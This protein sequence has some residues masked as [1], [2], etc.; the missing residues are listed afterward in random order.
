MDVLLRGTV[1][2]GYSFKKT[3]TWQLTASTAASTA[4]LANTLAWGRADAL[5]SA[6]SEGGEPCLDL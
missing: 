6:G 5:T 3:A 4:P 2:S 1:G